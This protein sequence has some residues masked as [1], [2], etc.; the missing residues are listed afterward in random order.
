MLGSDRRAVCDAV[1]IDHR[2]G[3]PDGPDP[4]PRHQQIEFCLSS[5][6]A[7]CPHFARHAL[8]SSPVVIDG[9]PPPSPD[10]VMAPTRLVIDRASA[11]SSRSALR[12]TRRPLVAAVVLVVAGTG[13]IGFGAVD[14]VASLLGG[15][16][17]P[18]GEVSRIPAAATPTA[19]PSHSPAPTA[20]PVSSQ[21]A[22]PSPTATAVASSAPTSVVLASQT[23]IVQPGDTLR[24]IADRYGT[25]VAA[26]QE[27]NGIVDQ[28]LI[29]AGQELVIP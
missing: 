27:A 4:V 26:L 18:E 25:T 20:T 5:A 24:A 16:G 22:S 15:T 28:N 10:V 6:H 7:E 1:D 9:V 14:R 11:S 3:V 13:A 2:C 17:D 12:P 29:E 21:A 19:T 8:L 23:Y